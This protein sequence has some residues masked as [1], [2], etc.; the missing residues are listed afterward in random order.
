MANCE[1]C[2]AECPA[3]LKLT[4]WGTYRKHCSSRCTKTAYRKAHPER[5]A[6]SKQLWLENNKEGRKLSSA[7]YQQRNKAYYN[8]YHSLRN[9]H[10]Q[11]ARPTWLNE[12]EE[13]WLDELYDLAKRRGME[14]DHIIP[15][16][17]DRVCGLHVP[18]NL[19]LLT[20]SQNAAKSNK[21]DEDVVAILRKEP[22]DG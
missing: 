21:F 18:W 1:V 16:K 4:R 13:L 12:F 9:R 14:V 20:R 10:M 2:G 22:I 19:Q 7:A 15:I 17:H 3:P 5:D 11:K 8:Q 6:A